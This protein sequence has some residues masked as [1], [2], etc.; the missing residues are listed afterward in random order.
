MSRGDAGDELL[1]YDATGLAKLV[2]AGEVSPQELVMATVARI[3]RLDGQLNAIS[4][5]LV[6]RAL[7]RAGDIPVD[8]LF[9][10]VPTLLKDL[11]D[12]AGVRR[13]SGSR[14]HLNHVPKE[15]VSYVR[16]LEEAGLNIIGM[17]NTPEFASLA[18]TDNHAFGPSR[19]PWN[20]AHTPGGSSGGSAVAVAAGYVP[21]AH[22][23]DGGGSNRI[24]SSC[25]GV[26]GMKA[27]RYRM[28]SGEADGQHFFLRTH[29]SISRTV[30]DSAALFAATENRQTSN[31]YPLEGQIA[32]PGRRRLKI[33]FS[34]T[35][36]FGR[37]PVPTVMEA[38]ESSARLCEEMGHEIIPVKNPLQ[39]EAFFEALESVML[40]S[41]PALLQQVESLTGRRAEDTGLL[42]PML[43]QT[44]RYAAGLPADAADLGMQYLQRL[45]EQMKNFYSS[46]NVWLTPTLPIEPPLEGYI[47]PD[48][49]F[50]ATRGASRDMLG[51]TAFANAVGS[52]AMS[53]PLAWSS[54]S[55]LPIGSH[56]S[57]AAGA[58]RTL[59]ELA[60][61]LEA[62]RPWRDRWAPYSAKYE[63]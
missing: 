53:V 37:E 3:E 17:T 56:F 13:T 33:A 49:D 61:E 41:M 28:A 18:L 7:Q 50:M 9:A 20:I 38:L 6:D 34:T 19:N 4:T 24:P 32:G 52:P 57:A 63:V 45:S 30:R 40:A 42:T 36:C 15:S 48:S 54:Q 5:L 60:Y 26:L 8:S 22:G 21:I 10:G 14:L 58:D 11:V 55:G 12:M 23:T 62:A 16:A 39:G 27:S 43:I 25:C 35:S 1:A 47:S 46:Y 29:Q 59:Y 31:P 51:Y 44:A 2:R